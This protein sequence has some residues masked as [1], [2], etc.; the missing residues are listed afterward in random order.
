MACCK[1]SKDSCCCRGTDLNDC[2][3][4]SDCLLPPGRSEPGRSWSRGKE[5]ELRW[6]REIY[7]EEQN[8]RSW[9]SRNCSSPS[10]GKRA[11]C[12]SSWPR[13]SKH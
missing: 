6:G 5:E 8:H 1:D 4:G 12:P 2:L 3:K 11:F 7:W 13:S 9:G 10:K